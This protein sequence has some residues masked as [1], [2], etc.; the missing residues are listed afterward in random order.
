MLSYRRTALH[1]EVVELIESFLAPA[2]RAVTASIGDVKPRRKWPSPHRLRHVSATERVTRG[3]TAGAI[4]VERSGAQ[5]WGSDRPHVRTT[6]AHYLH[7][8]GSRM[9]RA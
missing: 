3:S 4:S 8:G 1:T 2:C 5:L 6:L 7:N 9:R